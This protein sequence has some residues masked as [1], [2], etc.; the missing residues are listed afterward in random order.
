LVSVAHCLP[1]FKGKIERF[2]WVSSEYLPDTI[3]QII[4]F[5]TQ[6][7]KSGDFP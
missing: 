3:S 6:H 7:G 2:D 5:L 4:R 1:S